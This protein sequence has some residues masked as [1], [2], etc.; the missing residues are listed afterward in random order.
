MDSSVSEVESFGSAEGKLL[1]AHKLM[2]A[3]ISIRHK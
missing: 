1:F 3:G 2:E